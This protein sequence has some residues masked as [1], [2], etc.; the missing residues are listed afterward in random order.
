MAI[1]YAELYRR[2]VRGG[3]DIIVKFT[4]NALGESE[5]TTFHFVTPNPLGTDITARLS[6]KI[7]RMAFER[8]KLN[9]FDL[10]DDSHLVFKKAIRYIRNNPTVAKAEL[11]L[12]IKTAYP[13]MLW[14]PDKFVEK[15]MAHINIASFSAFKTNIVNNKFRG[16][17]G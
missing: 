8:N 5:T 7:W 2:S 12:A 16:I 13:N 17:D 10:G 9:E 11:I 6:N 14:K 4:D 15:I 3:V 1:T